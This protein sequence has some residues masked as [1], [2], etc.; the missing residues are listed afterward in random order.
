MI[1]TLASG[2]VLEFVS[3]VRDDSL[4]PLFDVGPISR[5]TVLA[6]HEGKHAS[7]EQWPIA[8]SDHAGKLSMVA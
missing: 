2:R 8:A 7:P 5:V 1:I 4:G 3:K 6:A